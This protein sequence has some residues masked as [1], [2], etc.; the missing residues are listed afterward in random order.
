MHAKIVKIKTEPQIFGGK[1]ENQNI[2]NV[3]ICS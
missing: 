3:N 1:K 2:K